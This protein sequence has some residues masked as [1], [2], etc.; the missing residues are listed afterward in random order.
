VPLS[1][2]ISECSKTAFGAVVAGLVRTGN[3]GG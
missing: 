1:S 2:D 3:P